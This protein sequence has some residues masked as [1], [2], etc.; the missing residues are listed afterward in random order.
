M[1]EQRMTFGIR[2][3]VQYGTMFLLS[4]CLLCETKAQEVEKN[5]TTENLSAEQAYKN[6]Q[7]AYQEQQ[8][9]LVHKIL[10][11]IIRIDKNF[12][13]AYLLQGKVN[14]AQEDDVAALKSYKK[15]TQLS[16]AGAEG[17]CLMSDLYKK[18][19]FKS[20][21]LATLNLGLTKF[22]HDVD[23]IY[24]RATC[25]YQSNQLD[26]AYLYFTMIIS[27]DP[28]YHKAYND[29]GVI[30]HIRNND[31]SAT[32]DFD[33]AIKLYADIRYTINKGI[34]YQALGKL[35]EA[36]D[37]YSE[38]LTI[39]PKNHYVRNLRGVAYLE[40][41]QYQEAIADFT[42]IIELVPEFE[43]A[44]NN[45]ANACYYLEDY[46]KALTFYDTAIKLVPDYAEAYF[47]RG[48]TKEVYMEYKDAS[49]DWKQSLKLGMPQIGNYDL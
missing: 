8:Y 41:K 39:D 11:Y 17:Y 49:E 9:G 45:L 33:Q 32:K 30:Q 46:G 15:Y 13:Q 6:A 3:F 48:N 7:Q 43:Y 42:T 40:S 29:R 27:L 1:T 22:P 37:V 12:A 25:Y 35:K 36:I 5:S 2:H 28:S 4:F 24:R 44:Y 10:D 14:Q 16:S 23:L 38:V 31:D 26:S 20:E 47:N 19:G 18:N 21:M 34:N